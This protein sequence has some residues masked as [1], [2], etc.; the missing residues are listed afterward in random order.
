MEILRVRSQCNKLRGSRKM[1]FPLLL[2]FI[3]PIGGTVSADCISYGGDSC[4]KAPAAETCRGREGT[5]RSSMIS[6]LSPLPGGGELMLPRIS[7]SHLPP[8]RC[9]TTDSIPNRSYRLLMV[10]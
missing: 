2:E 10:K 6:S 4:A 1:I 3:P 7:A 9:D 5:L 8:V